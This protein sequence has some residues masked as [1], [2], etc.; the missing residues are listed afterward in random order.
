MKIQKL[1]T[2]IEEARR[3]LIQAEG[4]YKE[5]TESFAASLIQATEM[6]ERVC[7]NQFTSSP[8]KSAAIKRSSMD[9][10]TALADLR[11]PN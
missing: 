4:L 11:K 1:K 7:L 8:K 10:S 3:F 9:L 6:S 2:A 5:H